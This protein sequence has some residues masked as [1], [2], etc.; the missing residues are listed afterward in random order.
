[1]GKKKGKKSKQDARGYSTSVIQGAPPPPVT[2]AQTSTNVQS[3]LK[4]GSPS[5]AL[6]STPSS[7]ENEPVTVIAPAL[8]DATSKRFFKKIETLYDQLIR[9][10]FTEEQIDT[11]LQALVVSSSNSFTTSDTDLFALEA[12]LD[13]FCLNL[14]PEEL[15]ALFTEQEVREAAVQTGTEVEIMKLESLV[16][17]GD[18]PVQFDASVDQH[19]LV[20]NA[21]QIEDDES[22]Q[23][24]AIEKEEAQKAWILNQYQFEDPE[25]PQSG[26]A[27]ETLLEDV[28][29]IISEE[30]EAAP[31]SPE[32]L[33]LIKLEKEVD[34]MRASLNDEASN[35]MRS[36]H[37]IKDL[38]KQFSM[39]QGQAKKLRGKVS[40][41]QVASESTAREVEQQPMPSGIDTSNND[42]ERYII[43]ADEEESD[44]GVTLGMFDEP[45]ESDVFPMLVE[46]AAKESTGVVEEIKET[47]DDPF[48]LSSTEESI[49]KGWT[50]TTPKKQLEDWCKKQKL[51]R[52][53]FTKLPRSR[54]G[55][56]VKVKSKPLERTFEQEGPFHDFTDAQQYVA[57]EALYSIM[58]DLPMY[59]MFPPVFRDLW[60]GWIS[61]INESKSLQK[62]EDR[63]LKEGRIRKLIELIPKQLQIRDTEDLATTQFAIDTSNNPMADI[64]WE[65][66]AQSN[67]AE[68]AE[69]ET[70]LGQ[71]LRDEF[72]RLRG[73]SQ[74]KAMEEIR[75]GLPMHKYKDIL[76]DCVTNNAVT[77]LCAETGAGKTTQGPQFMLEEALDAGV[78]DKSSII[79]TQPRRISAMSVAERVAD[80]M[81]VRLGDLVGYQI[82]GEVVKSQRTKLLFC[83][84]GVVLRRL[85]EDPSLTGITTVVVDE[86]HERSWQIDFLLI[87]LR[88]L[89]QTTRPDLKVVLVSRKR[90]VAHKYFECTNSPSSQMSATL[91]SELFCS[92]FGG[93]PLV[94]VPGRTYPVA[95]YFLEDLYDATN[96]T[97]EEDS[98]YTLRE[99]RKRGST[100]SLWVSKQGGD[101]RREVV[102]LD[103]QTDVSQVS[104]FYPG[105][106]INTQRSMDRV[107]EKVLNHDLIEDVLL[108][109]TS[110]ENDSIMTPSGMNPCI[111]SD[112]AFLIFLPG[113]AEIRSMTNRLT[114]SRFF[115][116]KNKFEVIPLHSSLSPQE[117]KR[118]FAKPRAGCRKIIISTNVAET[119]ITIPDVVCGMYPCLLAC[120]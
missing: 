118:A 80:E 34:E 107:D 94:N 4:K 73:T 21:A 115:G 46:P 17:T 72:V 87:A 52:P 22:K 113:M 59:R 8:S 41:I 3:L 120:T 54:S 95:T 117:Q 62:R 111:N 2:A 108:L 26:T 15:P 112:G 50:G 63:D 18:N 61:L 100:E 99:L 96:H 44:L 36:K 69:T 75:K 93:A 7:K 24:E 45:G 48:R 66:K 28:Q 35:Y 51:P 68:V 11:V 6:V 13:W 14:P 97:I 101:K 70:K 65:D 84:T 106:Q 109:L 89:L 42:E 12:A 90:L 64:D 56:R 81:C 33:R 38:K 102:E 74:Y 25:E 82:R 9:C 53:T 105:Y 60:K 98:M 85:Q 103:S 20:D 119:S 30:A 31:L 92:F 23:A 116:S 114:A 76:L 32:E 40:K 83:T 91:D 29:Q 77:V 78:G 43:T 47:M 16:Y 79:C 27:T 39:L 104:G 86:V 110:S 58:P 19:L 5:C 71:D 1:M 10:K 88:R 67:E 57:T 37:E 49:P 55:C